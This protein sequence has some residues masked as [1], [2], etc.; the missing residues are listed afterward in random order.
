MVDDVE[1]IGDLPRLRRC[2]AC[3]GCKLGSSIPTNDLYLGMLA[4]PLRE[5]FTGT[6]WDYEG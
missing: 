3:G 6:I 5:G 4:E 1:T 2:S